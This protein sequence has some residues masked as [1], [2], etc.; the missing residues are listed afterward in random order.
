MDM[1]YVRRIFAL[2]FLLCF[3]WIDLLI[4]PLYFILRGDFYPNKYNPLSLAVVVYIISHVWE[5]KYD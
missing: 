1:I 5:W 4:I 3:F 2:L